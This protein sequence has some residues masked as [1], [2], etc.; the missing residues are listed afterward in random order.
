MKDD[1]TMDALRRVGERLRA[2]VGGL[3]Q[4]LPEDARSISAMSRVLEIHKATCQR[5]VEGLNDKVEA[6]EG[7]ARFPGVAAL[8]MHASACERCGSSPSIVAETRA[9]IDEYATL[10]RRRG[11]T[12]EKVRRMVMVTRDRGEEGTLAQRRRK[13]LYDAASL[14]TGEHAEAKSLAILIMPGPSP[15]SSEMVVMVSMLRAEREEFAKPLTMMVMGGWWTRFPGM[16]TAHLPE[17]VRDEPTFQLIED[18]STTPVRAVKLEAGSARS[19]VLIES[20]AGAIVD[21]TIQF[22]TKSMIGGDQSHSKFVTAAA[23]IAIPIRTLILDVLIH[24]D[25]DV[26]PSATG[27]YSLAAAPG[28]RAE[29]APDQLWHERLADAPKMLE[30]DAANPPVST[31]THEGELVRR[32]LETGRVLAADVRAYRLEI[33]YPIWQSE[34]RV[35]F[36]KSHSSIGAHVVVRPT[37]VASLSASG[38]TSGSTSGPPSGPASGPASGPTG[39]RSQRATSIENR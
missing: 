10:L 14:V 24:K 28:D 19:V 36:A 26:V 9:A 4:T 25:L 35:Y 8:K 31:M 22:R 13:G 16:D 17:E 23:R 20:P 21:A 37:T 1:H 32:V 18:L 30:F 34:Y 3:V 29:G 6:V 39:T 7:L 5:V 11:L 2:A 12:H 15:S 27:C 38:S 33:K